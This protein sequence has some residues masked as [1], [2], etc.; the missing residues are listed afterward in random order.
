MNNQGGHKIFALQRGVLGT[1]GIEI[2][3][4]RNEKQEG[5]VHGFSDEIVLPMCSTG[6]LWQI[7]VTYDCYLSYHRASMDRKN[8][9]LCLTVHLDI[10]TSSLVSHEYRHPRPDVV[11]FTTLYRAEYEVFFFFS[12]LSDQS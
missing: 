3:H 1:E 10:R 4:W 11:V 6:P 12:F 2:Y 8:Q 5:T 7:E 9:Y